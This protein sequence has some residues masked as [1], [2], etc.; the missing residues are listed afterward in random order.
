MYF[1]RKK[2]IN[3]HEPTPVDNPLI[4]FLYDKVVIY[5]D[6]GVMLVV[7]EKPKRKV[8]RFSDEEEGNED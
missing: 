4:S 1:R 8:R 7:E 2:T 3:F 6:E 5:T